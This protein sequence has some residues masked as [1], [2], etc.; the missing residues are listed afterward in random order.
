MEIEIN[1]I[2]DGIIKQIERDIIEDGLEVTDAAVASRIVSYYSI[3]SDELTQEQKEELLDYGIDLASV[4]FEELS[5]V[6]APMSYD[7]V[8]DFNKY[9][10]SIV[11]GCKVP[12]EQVRPILMTLRDLLRKRESIGY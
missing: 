12:K 11:M 6:E 9:W 5:G 4:A 3:H 1:K 8:A 10:R 7:E 2:I